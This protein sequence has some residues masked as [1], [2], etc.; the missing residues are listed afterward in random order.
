M[1]S[2][3]LGTSDDVDLDAE[4]GGDAEVEQEHLDD[5]GLL[6]GPVA[7]FCDKFQAAAPSRALVT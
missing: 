7:G 6:G 3:W 2:A 4:I 5:L 1:S